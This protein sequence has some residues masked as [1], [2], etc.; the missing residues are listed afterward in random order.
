MA[1]ADGVQDPSRTTPRSPRLQAIRRE[2]SGARVPC[3]DPAVEGCLPKGRVELADNGW[4]GR[5]RVP[6]LEAATLEDRTR[7]P[8]DEASWIPDRVGYV[9]WLNGSAHKDRGSWSNKPVG[10]DRGAEREAAAAATHLDR[11]AERKAAAA[12]ALLVRR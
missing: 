8:I 4:V 12:E 10:K 3:P 11:D 2:G 1:R 7:P 9:A 5:Q 6:M